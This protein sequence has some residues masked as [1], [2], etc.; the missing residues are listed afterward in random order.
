[1]EIQPKQSVL[2]DYQ[3]NLTQPYPSYAEKGKHG[4]KTIHKALGL[5]VVELHLEQKAIIATR[6]R[7]YPTFGI[8]DIDNRSFA[9][10]EKIRR[11]IGLN[12][13]NSLI[14]SSESKDSYHV[15]FKPTRG[16][17]VVTLDYYY[18]A[19]SH[20]LQAYKLEIYPQSQR[21]IR[22][23]LGKGQHIVEEGVPHGISYQAG[24]ERLKAL[25]DFNLE[26]LPLFYFEPTVIQ[27]KQLS[28]TITLPKKHLGWK[29]DGLKCL[30]E[31]I[32]AF[33]TRLEAT[34][35]VIYFFWYQ[36]IP[37]KTT[38]EAT[39][40]WIKEKHNHKSKDFSTHP[41]KVYKQIEELVHWMYQHFDRQNIL[42]ISAH[43][44]NNGYLTQEL[45][46]TA[47]DA[48]QANLPILRFYL[49]LLAYIAPRQMEGRYVSVHS[50][51]LIDWSSRRS[52]LIYVNELQRKNLLI[53][54]DDYIVGD[55]SKGIL[56]LSPIPQFSDAIMTI[57]DNERTALTPEELIPQLYTVSEYESKLKN[58]QRAKITITKQLK[59]FYGL[60]VR[61]QTKKKATIQK[62]IA[63][64]K[65]HPNSSQRTIAKALNLSLGTVN[66]IV[67]SV[68]KSEK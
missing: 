34:K 20:A 38:I 32:T 4:W 51:R 17:R 65:K 61:Q 60:K 13:T 42:P 50:D 58:Y 53:R 64:I 10:V 30:N 2:L 23:P 41:R 11:H 49:R 33:G 68:Q 57:E 8:L 43:L 31:G 44:I 9:E 48:T 19:I 29:E 54:N 62:V 3:Y 55:H 6:G 22:L 16:G 35:R 67:Q 46:D 28:P 5:R 36:N 66:A 45:V 1:M 12:N 27:Y 63:Y 52:Y 26:T 39:K 18:Q 40:K 25:A 15:Y 24:Y 59:L 47:L 21:Y 14:F 7:Y 37:I 56:L